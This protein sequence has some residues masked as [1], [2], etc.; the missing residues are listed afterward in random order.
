MRRSTLALCFA[1]FGLF[2]VF[3]AAQNLPI[4]RIPPSEVGVVTIP[5]PQPPEEEMA[6][7]PWE[8]RCV[9]KWFDDI[10]PEFQEKVLKVIMPCLQAGKPT[11]LWL[12]STGGGITPAFAFYDAIRI[13]GYQEL[14]TTIALG[15]SSSAALIV[16]LASDRRYMTESAYFYLHEIAG[17][18]E[19]NKKDKRKDSHL[20]RF[21]N[22]RYAAI[23]AEHTSFGAKEVAAMMKRETVIDVGR[24]YDKGVVSDVLLH[25]NGLGTP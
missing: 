14:L 1:I 2:S 8:G 6:T 13:H 18:N 17:F 23:V 19:Q 15:E 9:M 25:H 4:P 10:T 3:A 11:T 5:I 7:I 24:A 22:D 20:I 12:T 21:L 16:L